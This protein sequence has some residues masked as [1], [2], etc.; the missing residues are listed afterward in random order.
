MMPWRAHRAHPA[1]ILPVRGSGI[2]RVRMAPLKPDGAAV[3]AIITKLFA[4]RR[5]KTFRPNLGRLLLLAAWLGASGPSGAI[6]EEVHFSPEE[7]LD[8]I[9]AALIATVTLG[10]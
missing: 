5:P 8:V 7:R 10:A 9:D 4:G 1:P 6:A 3:V 2:I